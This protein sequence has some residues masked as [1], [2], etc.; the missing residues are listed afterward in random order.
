MDE[1]DPTPA[2]VTAAPV[3]PVAAP[4][5]TPAPAAAAQPSQWNEAK[6]PKSGR[7]YWYN[8]VTKETTWKNPIP[9]STPEPSSSPAAASTTFAPNATSAVSQAPAASQPA[10]APEKSLA[11]ALADSD[12][13]DEAAHK[14][15]EEEAERE[16]QEKGMLNL[17]NQDTDSEDEGANFKFAKHRKGFFNRVLRT[18]SS[19]MDTEKILSWKKTLIKKALLKQNRELDAEAIQAF[20]NVM[21]YMGDRSSSKGPIEHAKKMIRN[22]MV[23]PSGLRDEVYVQI[24]K[25]LTKN[26]KVDSTVKGWELMR[27]C[28]ATFPPSKAV[29]TFLVDFITKNMEDTSN[30]P[31]VTA[32]ARACLPQID[33]ILVGQR[34]QIPSTLELNALKNLDTVK[35]EIPFL[36]GDVKTVSVDSYTTV[37]EV[38]RMV[39]SQMNL[40]FTE[41][42]GLYETGSANV[43]RLLE[44]KERVLDVIASWENEP[45]DTEDNHTGSKNAPAYH[46][47][48][49][50]LLYKAKLVLKLDIHEIVSDMEAIN[51]LYIQAVHDIITDRYPVKE[52][53][54]TVLA[55]LQLQALH[56]DYRPDVHSP[57][58]LSKPDVI[59]QYIPTVLITNDK[60]KQDHRLCAEWEEKIM[61]KYK[62][63]NGF[64]SLE[65]KTNY[66]QLV[67]EWIFYGATFFEVEQRQFKDYPSPLY[68]GVTCEG[69]L[70]LHPQKRTV[71]ENY[72]YPD[73]VTWGHS[74]E[75]FIV[76]VGNIVQQR[77]LI[78]KS[79]D[80]AT[81]NRLVHE[82]VRFKVRS[83]ASTTVVS[84]PE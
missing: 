26:P 59:T 22:L 10:A 28:L 31:R 27:Y 52:K 40:V 71:L 73:I 50:Q 62:K 70:L 46:S 38:E 55:A 42:F 33:K 18:K 81:I 2:A 58:W 83:K 29:K 17:T 16:A 41:P 82:Y 63:F 60:G 48:Y 4:A 64:T 68:V 39:T 49:N 66:L 15:A 23:A 11:A 53:D 19:I 32:L 20:K 34:K 84:V 54:T 74:D 80:G 3:V 35:L 79:G 8:K 61:Q 57:G 76:V 77:K 44:S 37:E 30:D 43:E 6:D 72:S 9:T 12:D 65:S 51:L 21:S 56:G 75:K 5:A 14:L 45:P 1:P 67:Q 13:E 25:Q 7:S 24:A 69:I 47:L 78:F 36:N